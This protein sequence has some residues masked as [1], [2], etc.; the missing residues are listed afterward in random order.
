[1]FLEKLTLLQFVGEVVVGEEAGNGARHNGK[2]EDVDQSVHK[3]HPHSGK[4]ITL[5]Y[6]LLFCIIYGNVISEKSLP[7]NS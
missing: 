5:K 1:V 2:V 3:V 4:L 6:R 7:G